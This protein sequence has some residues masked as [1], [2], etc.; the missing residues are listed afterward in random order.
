MTTLVHRPKN[1][2]DDSISFPN[3]QCWNPDTK[4]ATI[5]AQYSGQRVSCRIRFS[6]LR[7]KYNCQPAEPMQAVTRYR[8]AIEAAA[9]KLIENKKFEQDGSILI[10]Y[11]D[12]G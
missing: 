7:K 11:S 12:L 8:F 3:L 9:R 10:G 6:D 4:T 2:G 1:T 5:A